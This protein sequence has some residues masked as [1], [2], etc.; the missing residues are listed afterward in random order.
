MKKKNPI[1]KMRITIGTEEHNMDTCEAIIYVMKISGEKGFEKYYFRETATRKF[2]SKNLKWKRKQ[3]N[4]IEVLASKEQ[5]DEDLGN[6]CPEEIKSWIDSEELRETVKAD[7]SSEGLVSESTIWEIGT[8]ECHYLFRRD[9]SDGYGWHVLFSHMIQTK[10][11]QVILDN[12]ETAANPF[13]Q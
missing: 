3:Q 5:Y 12:E 6:I 1:C 9:N 10:E 7:I 8:L 2:N 13:T 4:G 11:T